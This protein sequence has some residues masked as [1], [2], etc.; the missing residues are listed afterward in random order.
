MPIIWYPLRTPQTKGVSIHN[1]KF[2]SNSAKEDEENRLCKNVI[3]LSMNWYM[4]NLNSSLGDMI[5]NK[6]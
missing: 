4:T 3:Y 6:M 2:G 1:P 5:S